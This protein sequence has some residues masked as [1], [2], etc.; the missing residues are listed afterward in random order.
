MIPN[1]PGWE[2]ICLTRE[3]GNEFGVPAY[4]ENDA[5]AAANG[6]LVGLMGAFAVALNSAG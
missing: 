1:L 6:D 4:L 2:G 5:N 3:F